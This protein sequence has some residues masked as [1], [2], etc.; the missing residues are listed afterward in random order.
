[1]SALPPSASF[2]TTVR[3]LLA[4]ARA[5]ARARLWHK[6]LLLQRRRAEARG[7]TFVAKRTG[8]GSIGTVFVLFFGLIMNLLLAA[9]FWMFNLTAQQTSPDADGRIT[10]SEGHYHILEQLKRIQTNVADKETA[11]RSRQAN[12]A[13]DAAARRN[14]DTVSLDLSHLKASYDSLSAQAFKSVAETRAKNGTAEARAFEAKVRHQYETLGMAGFFQRQNNFWSWGRDFPARPLNRLISLI[15]VT[16]W[17]IML[18]FQGEGLQLDFQRRRHPMWEWLF[19]HPAQPAAVFLAEMLAPLAANPLFLGAPFF[20]IGIHTVVYGEIG[21]SIVTGLLAG[22]PIALA[23]CCTSKALEITVMLRLSPRRRGAVLGLMSWMGYTAMVLALFSSG[24]RELMIAAVGWLQPL[25][26]AFSWPMFGW[27]VGQGIGE[28][29]VWKGVLVCWLL[30]TVIIVLA[31]TISAWATNKGLAGGF[32]SVVDTPAVLGSNNALRWLR[33]PWYRKELLWFWRDRGALVQVILVPLTMTVMQAL[34]LN[35]IARMT[36]YSWHM[37]AGAAVMFGTYFLFI[38]GPRSLISE[39]PAL[40]L[41]LTWPLDME[42]LLKAK[43]RMA[44]FIACG[45]VSLMLLGDV[46]FFP[47]DLWRI[48]LVAA[49]WFLFSRSLAEKV[50]TLV[51]I[52]SSAGEPDPPPP[53]QM[54]A[55]SLGTFTFAIGVFMQKWSLAFVGVVYSW[56]TCAAIWQNFRARLPFLFDPWSEKL[57]PAPTLMHALIA[58]SAMTEGMAVLLGILLA[59]LGR[60]AAAM[61]QSIAY[62]CAGVITLYFASSW[63]E[64]RGVRHADVWQWP[65]TGWRAGGRLWQK[66]VFGLLCGTAMGCVALGYVWIIHHTP[67]LDGLLV[68]AFQPG[69]R[70]WLLV[71][72]VAFAPVAE[73][74]LFR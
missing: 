37:L 46:L 3:L 11:L 72:A 2:W 42:V 24:A 10:I 53:G 33:N 17:F 52:P 48:L 59:T 74:C 7:E 57:P 15:V 29:S 66:L 39:G 73:E 54:L 30:S 68:H 63:M 21:R 35:N 27:L 13:A 70:L 45:V 1:M 56:L 49:G 25:A 67:M 55:V 18:A 19:S 5:R 32:D 23:A 36:G 60:D 22:V 26:Q 61:A 8:W 64:K 47:A 34:N 16:W 9:V 4:T 14:L 20:W 28:P 40:W 51:T 6:H 62:G 65:G 71:M 43:A 44:W 50:V 38:L 31:V 58:I 12:P 41:P 69:Q